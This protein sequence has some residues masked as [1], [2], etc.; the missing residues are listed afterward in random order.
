MDLDGTDGASATAIVPSARKRLIGQDGNI[1]GPT[2]HTGGPSGS[3]TNLPPGYVSEQIH[4]LENTSN[5]ESV[6]KSTMST[7]QKIHDPKRMRSTENST[8]SN[9]SA[10]PF[11]GD[12]RVL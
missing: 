9:I 1:N 3:G 2:V 10:T 12:R 5:V 4:L 8:T 7:P 11:E 6:D